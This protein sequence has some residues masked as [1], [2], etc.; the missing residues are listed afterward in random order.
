[1]EILA[2][3]TTTERAHECIFLPSQ[4]TKTEEEYGT[5]SI[6]P[7]ANALLNIHVQNSEFLLNNYTFSHICLSAHIQVSTMK[8][9]FVSLC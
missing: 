2:Y 4:N 1:M 6:T 3:S 9:N 5:Q 7:S 8:A